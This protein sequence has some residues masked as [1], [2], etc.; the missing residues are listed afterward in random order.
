MKG[1]DISSWQ[2]GINFDTLKNNV[3]FIILRAGYTG[4]GNGVNK[5]IDECF[6]DFYH[7][8]KLRSI[9]VGAYWYSCANTY[10]KGVAEAK[11][12]Y[13]N[14]LKGKQFEF[15]I[16]IDVEE[17]R[18][19]Q[20]G[21]G[22]VTQAIKG[23]CETLE[24]LGYY[25]GIYAN[26]NYFNNYIDTPILAN[27]DKWLANWTFNP[28]VKPTFKY[29]FFGLWQYSDKLNIAGYRLDGD[30]SYINYPN[31]IKKSKLNRF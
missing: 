24:K 8:C 31:L 25:V 17:S 14:C 11:Y 10:E 22:P 1:I 28:D 6:N 7:Q 30:V 26:T 3:D 27:Y 13:D 2:K 4:W 20:V 16:Y 18:H 5:N 23:F 19:Q 29:G 21:K 15:P 9:P 12:M